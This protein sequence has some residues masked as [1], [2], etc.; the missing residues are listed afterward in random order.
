MGKLFA[1]LYLLVLIL[2]SSSAEVESRSKG[3]RIQHFLPSPFNKQKI[4]SQFC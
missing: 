1:V 3:T 4:S 2:C